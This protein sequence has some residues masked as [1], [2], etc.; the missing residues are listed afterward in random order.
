MVVSG[1]YSY[2]N[3]GECSVSAQ[4]MLTKAQVSPI[5]SQRE[6]RM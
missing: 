2:L 5:F 1:L 6:S 4:E 3:L